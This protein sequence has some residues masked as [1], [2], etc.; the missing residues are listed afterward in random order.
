MRKQE[1]T[2][3]RPYIPDYGIEESDKGLLGWDFVQNQMKDAENYWLSTTKP[4]SHPHV[5]PTWGSW[6]N[7]NFYFGGGSETQNRK[8]LAENPHIVVH[9][10]SGVRVVI[11]EGKVSIE[12]EEDLIKEIKKDYMRKYNLDHPPP[13]YRVNKTKVFCWDMNDYVGT[14]T[15]WK[16]REI[17]E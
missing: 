8:N 16:F 13:F 10:E 14:P 1:R 6:I 11:I 15:R 12:K 17:K 2:R 4:N 3:D 5:I 7:D 9:S